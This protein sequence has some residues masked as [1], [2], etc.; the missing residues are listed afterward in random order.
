MDRIEDHVF[1]VIAAGMP[2]ND[3]AATADNHLADKGA[4]PDISVPALLVTLA[5]PA[6]LF[7]PYVEG[8]PRRKVR[9]RNLDVTPEIAAL[10]AVLVSKPLENP[11]GRMPRL[12]WFLP[13]F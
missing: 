10:E 2:R 9:D 12:A 1:A 13:V 7:E 4:D 11:L 3:L 8:I 6:L 5:F